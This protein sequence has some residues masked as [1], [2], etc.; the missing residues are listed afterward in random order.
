MCQEADQLHS[1]RNIHKR[2]PMGKDMSYCPTLLEWPGATR[3]RHGNVGLLSN[4]TGGSDLKENC[5]KKGGV[6]MSNFSGCCHFL[7]LSHCCSSFR[8]EKH[9]W[10]TTGRDPSLWGTITVDFRVTYIDSS[11]WD[12]VQ[13]CCSGPR[14]YLC[15]NNYM[16]S[17]CIHKSRET[18]WY[19]DVLETKPKTTS[20]VGLVIPWKWKNFE[21]TSCWTSWPSFSKCCFFMLPSQDF[22]CDF[23][24]LKTSTCDPLQSSSPPASF[25]PPSA[26]HRP[27]YIENHHKWAL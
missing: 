5:R 23:R 25:K 26:I 17:W 7:F 16:T 2:H 12:D 13:Y 11:A 15:P 3:A 8:E 4:A 18:P 14:W 6:C 1:A 22:T 19:L 24:W 9:S 20:Q 27:T 10:A 21:T